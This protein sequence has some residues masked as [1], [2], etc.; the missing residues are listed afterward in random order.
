MR[1]ASSSHQ[2]VAIRA[3]AGPRSLPS[4]PW[5]PRR[6]PRPICGQPPPTEARAQI[7][8][9]LDCGVKP[10]HLD[11]HCGSVVASPTLR[12]AAF[13]LMR[14]FGIPGYALK[15]RPGLS[16]PGCFCQT[17]RPPRCLRDPAPSRARRRATSHLPCAGS[18]RLPAQSCR[19]PQPSSQASLVGGC[20]CGDGIL[21][22]RLC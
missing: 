20:A 13:E 10:T 5:C 6:R 22:R 3:K 7:R 8:F 19:L 11:Y 14:E 15:D 9:A 17:G 18:F 1:T 16:R 12:Q 4:A 21:P 2:L